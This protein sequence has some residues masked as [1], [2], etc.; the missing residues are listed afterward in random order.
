MATFNGNTLT[1]TLDSGVTEVDVF[2]DIYEPWKDWLLSATGSIENRKFPAAFRSDG[3]NPLSSVI[4]QG[5]YIFLNN[6][7]GWRIKPPE[8][9]ITIYLT[10]NLAVEDTA[11]PAFKPTDGAFTAAILGLQPVT[12]GVTPEMKQQL[13][14]SAYLGGVWIDQVSGSTGTAYPNGAEQQPVA[15]FDD[16]LAIADARGF[17][18]FFVRGDALVDSG[19]DYSDFIFEGQGQNLTTFTIT[20][21]ANVNN[22]AFIY[23]TITGTLDGMSRLDECIIDNLNFVSGVIERCI[24]NSTVTLGGNASAQFLNCHSGVAGITTPTVDMG[25]AGQSLTLRNYNG[26][27]EITNKTGPEAISIDLVAGQVIV[28]LATVTD[29]LLVVRGNGKVVRKSDGSWLPSGSYGDLTV[30]N[31]TV[32]SQMLQDL[33]AFNGLDVNNPRLVTDG[34]IVIGGMTFTMNDDGTTLTLQRV[35]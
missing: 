10:G 9:N 1:I 35:T 25:G 16:G 23:A 15:G 2:E 30:V 7:A 5:G 29:G 17:N 31:E 11:L 12:Q 32:H 19:L 24:L 28:D 20:A 8:E 21:A 26:G 18:K 34:T 27:V 6:A 4:N 22:C 14:H 13:E 33:W 3:G